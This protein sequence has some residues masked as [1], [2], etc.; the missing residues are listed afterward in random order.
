M[1]CKLVNRECTDFLI[2]HCEVDLQ[3][4]LSFSKQYSDTYSKYISIDNFGYV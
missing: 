4:E 2:T 3:M 1:P